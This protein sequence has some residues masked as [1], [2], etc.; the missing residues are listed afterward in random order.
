MAANCVLADDNA[1]GFHLPPRAK[2]I[3]FLFMHGGPSHINLFDYKPKL[4]KLDGESLPFDERKVQF[5]KRGAIM[6]PPWEFRQIAL[7]AGGDKQPGLD[8][9]GGFFG[10]G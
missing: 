6:A 8:R 5:A 9:D 4:A 10:K 1:V 7:I 3:I 2:Q